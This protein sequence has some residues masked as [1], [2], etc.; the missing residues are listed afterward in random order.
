M[1][2]EQIFEDYPCVQLKFRLKNH[3]NMLNEIIFNETFI[4]ELGYSMDAFV[5]LVLQE[6]LPQY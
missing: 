4:D 2:K 3:D 5:T 6:G 1:L